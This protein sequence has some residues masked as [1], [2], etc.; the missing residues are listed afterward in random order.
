LLNPLANEL[1]EVFVVRYGY[2]NAPQ[3]MA[4]ELIQAQLRIS[5]LERKLEK[6]ERKVSAGYVRRDPGH[7]SR[8][9][10]P[11]LANPITDDWVK[12]G[13]EDQVMASNEYAP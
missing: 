7:R 13:A 1:V 8:Q 11:Q 9:P 12:T 4:D 6:E 10:K 3:A 2:S 5:A